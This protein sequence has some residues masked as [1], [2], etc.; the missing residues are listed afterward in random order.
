MISRFQS[1]KQFF[2]LFNASDERDVKNGSE[3]IGKKGNPIYN[4]IKNFKKLSTVQF[5]AALLVS[6]VFIKLK[7]V[8]GSK[9][10]AF[11]EAPYPS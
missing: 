2:K 9:L 7:E 10:T 6:V 8:V 1:G 4:D 11:I 3:Y 5:D